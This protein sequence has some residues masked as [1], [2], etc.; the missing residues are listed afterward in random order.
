MNLEH[1][2]VSTNNHPPAHQP[3]V[4]TRF[5][6]RTNG[7]DHNSQSGPGRQISCTCRVSLFGLAYVQGHGTLL[8][9]LR[10]SSRAHSQTTARRDARARRRPSTKSSI[11]GQCPTRGLPKPPSLLGITMPCD[12]TAFS[13]FRSHPG[14]K[15]RNSGR[16]LKP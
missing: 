12:A 2:S 9:P 1:A 3:V 15:V 14:A 11:L 10:Q 16:V 5:H 6:R 7:D 4:L 13:H 8:R